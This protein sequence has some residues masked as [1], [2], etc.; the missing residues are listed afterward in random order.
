MFF[1]VFLSC[2][3]HVKFPLYALVK[4]IGTGDGR[5]YTRHMRISQLFCA[6]V[7]TRAQKELLCEL[8]GLST[9][10]SAGYLYDILTLFPLHSVKSFKQ[11]QEQGGFKMLEEM[12][13]TRLSFRVRYDELMPTLMDQARRLGVVIATR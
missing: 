4:M 9:L 11:F 10:I 6:V 2:V 3:P 1:H 13:E 7:A 8:G 12:H 5:H